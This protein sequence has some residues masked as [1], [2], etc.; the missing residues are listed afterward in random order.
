MSWQRVRGHDLLVK[1]FADVLARGRLGHAYLFVGPSG[2]GKRLFARELAKAL[3]CESRGK[4]FDACD[5]CPGCTT[6][7]AGTHP[8]LILAARPEDKNEFP[9]DVIRELTEKLA[10]KPSRGGHKVAVID[11]ADDF[12]DASANAFL[13]TL[14]EPPPKSLLILIGTDPQRQLP[15]IVSRCQLVRFAPLP[16]PLI[17]ELLRAGGLEPERAERLA[18]LS[19]GSLGQAHDLADD[20]LWS[21]RG[22]LLAELARPR[23]DTVRLGQ[24][25]MKFVEEAGKEGALQRRRAALTMHLLVELL[26]QALNVS[27]AA[28]SGIQPADRPH[29]EALAARL[30][31]DRLL[32]L[33]DRCLEAEHHLDR[34]VQLVLAVEALADSL[35]VPAA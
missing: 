18:R 8:D 5:A 22:E 15:T 34:K 12:N 23:P 14:E 31:P 7:E 11:D 28:G 20:A 32:R 17:A 13:K 26:D 16:A 30:G 33:I 9:I 4:G 19:G 25:W 10:L 24:R 21:F 6:A 27:V 29:L 35:A 1:S 2:V 3:L